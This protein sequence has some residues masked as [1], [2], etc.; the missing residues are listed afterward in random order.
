MPFVPTMT[1]AVLSLTLFAP[2]PP[3]ETKGLRLPTDPKVEKQLAA[4]QDY[5]QERDWAQAIRLLQSIVDHP[6]EVF[7]STRPPNRLVSAQQEAQ[8]QIASLPKPGKEFYERTYRPAALR[9]LQEAREKKNANLLAEVVR[10]FLHTRVGPEALAELAR[11]HFEAKHMHRAAAA[12]R[13]L[14]A[15]RPLTDWEPIRLYR[16][17]VAC[18]E[19]GDAQQMLALR[20]ALLDK[21]GPRGLRVGDKVLGRKEILKEFAAVARP[22]GW[23]LFRGDPQ[24][25]NQGKGSAPFLVPRWTRAVTIRTEAQAWL[26]RARERLDKQGRAL[27]P[28]SA[29]LVIP[30]KHPVIVFRSNRGLEAHDPRTGKLYWRSLNRWSLDRGLEVNELLDARIHQAFTFWLQHYFTQENRPEVVFENSLSGTLSSDGVNIYAIADL[31]LPPQLPSERGRFGARLPSDLHAAC[32]SNRL[33]AYNLS[34]EGALSWEWGGKFDKSALAGSFFLGPPLPI[35]GELYVLSQKGED[36]RL[37]RLDPQRGAVLSVQTLAHGVTPLVE[38]PGRRLRAV[39]LAAA[40]GTLVCPPPTGIVFGIDLLTGKSRWIHRYQPTPSPS[41]PPV[42][43]VVPGAPGRARIDWHDHWFAPTPVIAGDRVVLAPADAPAVYC[44]ALRDGKLVWKAN[45]REGDLYLAGAFA[46]RV[47]LVGKTQCRALNLADGKEVWSLATGLPSGLGVGSGSRY[48]LPLREAQ[49][50]KGPAVC[51]LDVARGRVISYSRHQKGEIPGNLVLHDGDVISLTPDRLAVYPQLEVILGDVQ[52]RL[53]K[54]ANDPVGL[55]EQGQLQQ[56]KGDLAG[57]VE[58][59]RRALQNK[60]PEEVLDKARTLLFEVLSDYLNRDYAKAVKYLKEYRAM[61]ERARDKPERLRRLARYHA[62]VGEG[63][64]R[65]GNHLQALDAYLDLAALGLSGEMLT[66]PD[67]PARQVRRDVWVQGRIEQLLREVPP[68]SR[69]KLEQEIEKRLEKVRQGKAIAPLRS[70]V[71]AVG[72]LA[73]QARLALAKRLLL[74][75]KYLEADLHLQIARASA[76][77]KQ[78]ARALQLLVELHTRE[79]QLSEALYHARRLAQRYPDVQL[80][81]GETGKELLARLGTD[82]RFLPYLDGKRRFPSGRITA[83]E[84]KGT[85][86]LESSPLLHH[87]E[88]LPS[89]RDHHLTFASKSH[90]FQFIDRDSGKASWTTGSVERPTPYFVSALR[91]LPRPTRYQAPYYTQGLLMVVPLPDLVLGLDATRGRVLWDV[92]VPMREEETWVGG[93]STRVTSEPDGGLAFRFHD[94]KI[95]R[96]GYLPVFTPTR[97]CLPVGKTLQALDP[98]TGQRLWTRKDLAGNVQV[99]GDARALFVVALDA[100]GQ[101]SSTAAYRTRDGAPV[102]IPDFTGPYA[103]RV[104]LVGSRML[105]HE[106]A[107]DGPVLAL[108]DLLTGKEVW[109]RLFPKKSILI[110]S[111]GRERT[112]MVGPDGAFSLLDIRTGKEVFAGKLYTRRHLDKVESVYLLEDRQRIYLLT[113]RPIDSRLPARLTSTVTAN[114]GLRSITVNGHLYAFRHGGKILWFNLIE[115]QELILNHFQELPFVLF[116]IRKDE[117]LG[118]GF[119]RHVTKMKAIDKGTGKHLLEHETSKNLWFHT[120][121]I[122]KSKGTVELTGFPQRI[123][124]EV[125]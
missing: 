105:I 31:S 82:K 45:R 55:Y 57:A 2:D 51:V 10:R 121:R 89:F 71:R 75:R 25:T 40:G 63:E 115:K 111:L 118:G 49:V 42:G 69:Q 110:Q 44:L 61:C 72:R 125:R 86:T 124:F 62:L 18:R 60:P 32:Q 43:R 76:E 117:Q 13:Q 68:E 16:A 47:L 67:D 29:P 113:Q 78:V 36:L 35:D 94:G 48:F 73:G 114:S 6:E 83:R 84:E 103:R 122:N 97:I 100:E 41:H 1:C 52:T 92:R 65:R 123:L 17:A 19:T 80:P 9:L 46:D 20:K 79:G 7:V 120:L 96:A 119:I 12:Y 34:R 99:F 77:P 4:A 107:K 102:K 85:W 38:A 116:A 58:S 39:H 23:P 15:F 5:L 26:D 109:R 56:L 90:Q 22:A 104:R 21:L 87:G 3:A 24:R 64:R 53:K 11:H 93:S 70:L 74:S 112:G 101:P 27:L 8:K 91:N 33:Q 98:L 54:N 37:A 108:V 14:L 88:A 59:V 95:R 81:T 66:P 28:A 106:A 30:G 50:G